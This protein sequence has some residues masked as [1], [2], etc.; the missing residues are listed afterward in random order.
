MTPEH[1][2]DPSQLDDNDIEVMRSDITEPGEVDTR[3]EL[4]VGKR[5]LREL[6]AEAWEA[7]A[8]MNNGKPILFRFGDAIARVE[9]DEDGRGHIRLLGRES[10]RHEVV[11]LLRCVAWKKVKGELVKVDAIP[12]GVL[13]D[14]LLAT[15]E[16]SLPRIENAQ[17]R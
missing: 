6:G 3:A 11:K 7:I 15:A 17:A 5:D 9:R 10:L 8:G 14:D 12:P 16:P 4:D 1:R 13:L 2:F